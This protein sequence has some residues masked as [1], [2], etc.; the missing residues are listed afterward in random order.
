[1]KIRS[2]PILIAFGLTAC[3]GAPVRSSATYTVRSGDTLYSIATRL[4]V[5]YRDLARWNG[6]GRDY[7]IYPGQ[8]LQLRPRSATT[9]AQPRAASPAKPV[10]APPPPSFKWTW[11]AAGLAVKSTARPNGGLGLTIGGREDQD[12]YAAGPGKVVYSGTGLLGY[13]QLLIIKHDDT[14]LS[15][16]GYTRTVLV[17]EGALVSAGQKVA[18]MGMDP[19][20]VPLLYFEIRVNGKPV[21]PLL[22]LPRQP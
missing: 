3:G 1:M 4:E 19:A 2:I 9:A 18:T 11:P 20:G 17:G 14:Y 16:Y 10:A 5:D 8:V 12:I 6:I 22:L 13:G 15:A 21:D 7:R